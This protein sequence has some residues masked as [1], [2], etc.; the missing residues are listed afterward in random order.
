LKYLSANHT[1]PAVI[2]TDSF[3]SLQLL[4]QAFFSSYNHLVAVIQAQLLQ[5]PTGAF[6]LQWVSSHVGLQGNK[7]AD[8]A[9]K[10]AATS[11]DQTVQV[12][13][14]FSKLKSVVHHSIWK[15]WQLK[16]TSIRGQFSLG[17]IKPSV[18]L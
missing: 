16:W 12:P 9:A 11:G 7:A 6:H 1:L 13:Y 8:K 10:Q 2:F 14:D 17:M 5:L 18:H 4:W 15:F 3:S